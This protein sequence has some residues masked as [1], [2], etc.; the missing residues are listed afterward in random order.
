MCVLSLWLQSRALVM[1]HVP[2]NALLHDAQAFITGSWLIAVLITQ[3]LMAQCRHVECAAT[4]IS[5]KH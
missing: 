3:L 2:L 4:S 5:K 1:V